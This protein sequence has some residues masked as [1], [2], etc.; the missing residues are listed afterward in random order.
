MKIFHCAANSGLLSCLPMVYPACCPCCSSSLPAENY[1][2]G[3]L[4]LGSNITSDGYIPTAVAAAVVQSVRPI[5]NPTEESTPS[6]PETDRPNEQP[7]ASTP[8]ADRPNEQPTAS[9]PETARPNE[10]PTASAPEATRPDEQPTAS[11]PETARPNEETAASM[12][13]RPLSTVRLPASG[14]TPA[15][16]G[17]AAQFWIRDSQ[18]VNA[19]ALRLF[20]QTVAGQD[21]AFS[22]NTLSLAPK[23][24]YFVSLLLKA[25][26]NGQFVEVIPQIDLALRHEFSACANGDSSSEP[27]AGAVSLSCGFLVNTTACTAPTL[28][29]F[30]LHTD[31][32]Q[33]IA[34]NGCLSL[35]K[36][37]VPFGD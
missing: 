8:D 22:E 18:A 5:S 28:L 24:V 25:Q 19:S 10:Q 12:P 4:P 9:T 7:T 35:F 2:G 34:V 32:A 26:A 13:T 27:Q 17:S 23:G 30:L 29:Q 33:P 16:A 1:G 6:A 31:S 21:L 36:V 11:A 3:L 37:G 15:T 20:P 14:D